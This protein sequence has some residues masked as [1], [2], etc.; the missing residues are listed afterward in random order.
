MEAILIDVEVN[1]RL[2]GGAGNDVGQ[3]ARR[4]HQFHVAA[5]QNHARFLRPVGLILRY[6]VWPRAALWQPAVYAGWVA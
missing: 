5:R 1:L 3:P 4:L 6:G 2:C